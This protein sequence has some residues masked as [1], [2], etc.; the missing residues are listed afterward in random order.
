M[1][2]LLVLAVAGVVAVP[3][4]LAVHDFADVPT[5]SVH[6]TDISRIKNAGITGGCNPPANTLYCPADP[7]R[8][9]QMGSFLA[10]ANGRVAY[11]TGIVNNTIVNS[12]SF[13]TDVEL[14]TLNIFPG[15]VTGG[16]KFV[17]V[18]AHFRAAH[19]TGTPPYSINF[20]IA[21]PTCADGATAANRSPVFADAIRDTTFGNTFSVSFVMQVPS[22]EAVRTFKLC[23]FHLSAVTST[24]NTVVMNALVVPHGF[25]GGNTLGDPAIMDS[26]ARP[27]SD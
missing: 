18:D 15:G 21:R 23:A 16:A 3:A 25:N 5:A 17:K 22:G 11:T 9:D 7:V 19:T 20:Y 24:V 1:R 4:A 12:G 14:A 13:A 2:T 10:R 8:R 27:T 26:G 6:H